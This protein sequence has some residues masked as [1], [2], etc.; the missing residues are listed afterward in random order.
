MEEGTLRFRLLVLPITPQP[1]RQRPGVLMATTTH[2]EL[3]L[4]L[5]AV[6]EV[7]G[8]SEARVALS[9]PVLPILSPHSLAWLRQAALPPEQAPHPHLQIRLPPRP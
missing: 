4:V 9:V 7:S 5:P 1:A 3:F 2:S 6:P 8:G